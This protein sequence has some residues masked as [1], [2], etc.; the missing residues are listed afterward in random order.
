MTHQQIKATSWDRNIAILWSSR[1]TPE[2]KKNKL[3]SLLT[4]AVKNHRKVNTTTELSTWRNRILE[5]SEYLMELGMS[6]IEIKKAL[7]S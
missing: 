5:T 2:Q 6:P 7:K 1:A 3:Y 4:D